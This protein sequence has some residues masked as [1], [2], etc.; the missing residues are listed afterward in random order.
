MAPKSKKST[1]KKR[2]SSRKT[3][4]KKTRTKPKKAKPKKA[5]A[6]P[7]AR[8][9]KKPASRKQ[10]RRPAFEQRKRTDPEV[11]AGF[12]EIGAKSLDEAYATIEA[13]LEDAIA[14]LP[15]GYAGKVMMHAYV[16]GS[17]D[18]ELRVQVPEDQ[19]ARDVEFD[20]YDAF[21]RAAV[22][23]RYWFSMGALYRAD[24]DDERYRR[25]RGMIMVQTNYQRAVQANIV[26]EHLILRNKIMTG[27]DRKFGNETT[28]AVFVRLHWNPENGQPKR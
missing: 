12:E 27:M 1:S 26:E 15:E 20:L 23:R 14:R 13:R 19:D 4:S 17:V 7:K 10:S 16:D 21:D 6:K 11:P 5:K 25:N 22:G 24:T 3:S 8:P 28:Y 18:G 9:R 2:K